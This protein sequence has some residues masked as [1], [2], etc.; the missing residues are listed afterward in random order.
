MTNY[1]KI[2]T[3]V[4]SCLLVICFAQVVWAANPT[5]TLNAP[6]PVYKIEGDVIKADLSKLPKMKNSELKTV[7]AD[8]I[9]NGKGYR[10]HFNLHLNPNEN[11]RDLRVIEFN[12]KTNELVVETGILD[13]SSKQ[14]A[15]KKLSPGTVSPAS[16]YNTSVTYKSW[17]QDPVEIT[18][19][20]IATILNWSYDYSNVGTYS[21]SYDAYAYRGITIWWLYYPVEHS[22][23]GNPTWCQADDYAVFKNTDFLTSDPTYVS[24]EDNKAIGYYD[25]SADG[26]VYVNIYG[27]AYWMLHYH[28]SLTRNY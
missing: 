26:D 6:D 8:P 7:K 25:G 17:A 4:L 15:N 10:M 5:S 16:Y 20:S 3:L 22:Q 28:S 2:L 14:Q 12:K 9:E 24:Y 18:V 1:K 21:S 13:D 23:S 11:Q 19:N 27:E